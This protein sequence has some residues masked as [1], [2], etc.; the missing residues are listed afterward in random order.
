MKEVR[1]VAKALQRKIQDQIGELERNLIRIETC[2]DR[3]PKTEP[4][5]AKLLRLYGL[6]IKINKDQI[7]E[8]KRALKR[9]NAMFGIKV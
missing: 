7:G 9:L 8:L 2:R 1:L 5:R 3:V 6:Y 4:D